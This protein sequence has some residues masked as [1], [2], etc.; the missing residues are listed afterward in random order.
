MRTCIA[1]V[2][3]CGE[4]IPPPL[5]TDS[6]L[7]FEPSADV[8]ERP[9]HGSPFVIRPQF[10]IRQLLLGICQLVGQLREHLLGLDQTEEERNAHCLTLTEGVSS[11]SRETRN[12]GISLYFGCFCIFLTSVRADATCLR[13][14]PSE[15]SFSLTSGPCLFMNSIVPSSWRFCASDCFRASPACRSR[16]SATLRCHLSSAVS[17]VQASY[18]REQ[19]E[20]PY[21]VNC[22]S[23]PPQDTTQQFIRQ[24]TIVSETK[25]ST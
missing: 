19:V 11:F 17:L 4:M 3:C 25:R 20:N 1:Y 5:L 6:H 7:V 14:S 18:S 8:C 9:C 2:V 12:T 10:V 15:R 13:L 24:N 16:S 21:G 22:L 23:P